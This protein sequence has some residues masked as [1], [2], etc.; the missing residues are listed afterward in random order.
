MIKIVNLNS[1]EDI[2]DQ[3]GGGTFSYSINKIGAKKMIDYINTFGIRRAIDF[4]IIDN[5]NIEFYEVSP[6]ICVSDHA[7][8]SVNID[9][10][11]QLQFDCFNFKH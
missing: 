1:L 8:D 2:N 9:T 4:T 3:F 10:N 7:A 6:S 11:I 5:L